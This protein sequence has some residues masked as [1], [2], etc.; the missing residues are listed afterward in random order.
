MVCYFSSIRVGNILPI[1]W[2]QDQ[3]GQKLKWRPRES[4][5]YQP[6]KP[7]LAKRVKRGKKRK[8][9]KVNKSKSESVSNENNM[10][11]SNY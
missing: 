7:K 1:A 8:P 3:S 11:A 2:I 10:N 4:S 6:K 9:R 5:D